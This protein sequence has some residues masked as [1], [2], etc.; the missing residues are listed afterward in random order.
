MRFK[1]K[2]LVCKS[3]TDRTVVFSVSIFLIRCVI[4]NGIVG[5]VNFRIGVHEVI[6]PST[7]GANYQSKLVFTLVISKVILLIQQ[8]QV[9]ECLA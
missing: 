8:G 9:I 2:S 5:V 4:T 7:E 6:R 1:N 3:Q